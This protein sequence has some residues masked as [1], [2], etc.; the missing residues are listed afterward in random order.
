MK[1]KSTKKDTLVA[2]LFFIC[3]FITMS[4]HGSIVEDSRQTLKVY[5]HVFYVGL[6]YI[7][8]GII[9]GIIG[10]I[11]IFT[12]KGRW[13]FKTLYFF[14]I[15]IPSIYLIFYSYLHYIPFLS[16]PRKIAVSVLGTKIWPIF[17]LMF[18]YGLVTSFQKISETENINKNHNMN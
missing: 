14:V 9:L 15:C 4:I 17:G 16:L 1:S 3:L 2:V 18:G 5:P 7:P 8:L 10:R 12:S 6:I 13:Q 11:D